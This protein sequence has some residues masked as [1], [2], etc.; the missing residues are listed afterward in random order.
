MENLFRTTDIATLFLNTDLCIQKYTPAAQKIFQFLDTDLGRPISQLSTFSHDETLLRDIRDVLRTSKP[1][2]Q[3]RRFSHD[4][5]SYFSRITPYKSHNH[6][7][8]GIVLTFVDITHLRS[9]ED[10]VLRFSQQQK[11]IAAF[12]QV[13][14]Q[15]R[16]LAKVMD[17]GVRRI[18]MTLSVE[19]AKVLELLPDGQ[20]LLLRAGVGWKEGLVG[21]AVVS[22]DRDSQAGYTLEVDEPVIVA[23]L[24]Q[25]T[26]F[27]GPA[28]LIDHQVVS[29]MSCIIRDQEGKPHGV[30][31]VHTSSR[32][33]FVE[34]DVKFLQT[35]ANI[36]AYAIHRKNIETQLQSMTESLER[37][38]NERTQALVRHQQRLRQLSSELILTEQRERR[39]IATELHDYLGQLLVVGKIKISQLQQAGLPSPQTPLVREIEET[40]D[41]ALQYTRDLIP[42]ISPPILYEFGLMAAIRWLAEK[43][44]RYDLH[45]TVT[46]HLDDDSLCFPESVSVILYQVIRELL[47]NVMKHAQTLE[48]D[49]L[50]TQPSPAFICF[51]VRDRG[52]GFN[53]K[54]TRHTLPLL[55]KFGLLNVQERV[56]SLGGACEIHSTEGEGTRVL[57]TVPFSAREDGLDSKPLSAPLLPTQVS[58]KEKEKIRVVL[59]DDHPIFREGLGTL[60][61]VCPDIQVVGEAENGEQAVVLGQT[62]Q[63]DVVVMDINM[64]VMNGIEAT[65]LIKA[66]HP[67]I[68]VIGLSMHGDQIVTK[69]FSEAGGDQYVTKGDSFNSFAEVIRSSQKQR[70]SS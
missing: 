8:Q 31:G 24:S 52:C 6:Q 26:R 21:H 55:E 47:L 45:V 11:E 43:M 58:N 49:I 51:E 48:A 68:Y 65:R 7:I 66:S 4:P 41:E 60:L 22:A 19:Y 27:S 9:V 35:M 69:A 37:R 53:L 46:S 12:G 16:D 64:P 62:L 50:I 20:S 56:E 33:A 5:Q 14:I 44:V 42:Q 18:A 54:A 23:D 2:Q 38:V 39:R 63:P 25:E 30:L 34:E 61:N 67:S 10:Q 70:G 17:D 1:Q 36:L 59:A 57:I 28:L 40:M 29:G 3:T 15:E 32:K 13:A